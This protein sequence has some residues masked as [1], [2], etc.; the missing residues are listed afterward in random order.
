M[1]P[2]RIGVDYRN[3]APRTSWDERPMVGAQ[4]IADLGSVEVAMRSRSVVTFVAVLAAASLASADPPDID[5]DVSSIR[6][7]VAHPG[8][9]SE[10]G[11]FRVEVAMP[12]GSG[13]FLRT[14]VQFTIDGLTRDERRVVV[15]LP[16]PI[17]NALSF[18]TGISGY[19]AGE[20]L[21]QAGYVSVAID[22][23]GTEGSSAPADGR[24]ATFAGIAEVYTRAI[25]RVSRAFRVSRVDVYGEGGMGGEVGLLLARDD[26]RVRSFSASG[27]VYLYT[28]DIAKL[29]LFNQA[30]YDFFNA[31]ADG[32]FV[33]GPELYGPSLASV[34]PALASYLLST[35]PGRYP[36]GYALEQF[37]VVGIPTGPPAPMVAVGPARVPALIITDAEDLITPPIDTVQLVADYGLSGGGTASLVV[38]PGSEHA[39]R[40]GV[41]QGHGPDSPFWSALLAFLAA[42]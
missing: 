2:F 28:T 26:T 12:V 24:A 14:I 20:I 15:L 35:Q 37:S 38:V 22:A 17:A 31:P 11:V 34:P 4:T 25:D 5:A 10:A 33:A 7:A 41:T 1:K 32:Y 21:A 13:Q 3:F 19:D 16:G 40:Y 42:H 27:I 30:Q 29:F 6:T 18:A 8:V 9:A 23:W 36:S 39:P